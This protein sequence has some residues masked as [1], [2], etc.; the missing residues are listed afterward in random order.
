MVTKFVS[1]SL[2]R[3]LFGD[4][5]DSIPLRFQHDFAKQK[6]L[7]LVCQWKYIYITSTMQLNFNLTKH[8]N[9]NIK[10]W[11]NFQG[12]KSLVGVRSFKFWSHKSE[13]GSRKSEVGSRKSGVGTQKSELRS[14]NSDVGSRNSEVGTQKSDP[15][16]ELRSRKSEVP[17]Q[18]PYEIMSLSFLIWPIFILN[19][20]PKFKPISYMFICNCLVTH[21]LHFH[22]FAPLWLLTLQ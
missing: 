10:I 13:V 9:T 14:W 8:N 12:N 11:P 1:F 19:I 18:L 22:I 5:L 7:F 6:H 4:V 16:S 21:V 20:K 15:K 3:S 2:L 17:P